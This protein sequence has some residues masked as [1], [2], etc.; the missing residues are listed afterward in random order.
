VRV[1]VRDVNGYSRCVTYVRGVKFT[2]ARAVGNGD[3]S[4]ANAVPE[5]AT[6]AAQKAVSTTATDNASSELA[7]G[8]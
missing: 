1:G 5:S 2:A 6:N 3:E 8:P 4:S 7:A